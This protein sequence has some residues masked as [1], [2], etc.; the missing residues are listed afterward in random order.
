MPFVNPLRVALGEVTTGYTGT[1]TVTVGATPA[2]YT[3]KAAESP[4]SVM[5]LTL[6]ECIRV[7]GA[8]W[9]VFVDSSDKINFV[10]SG[11]VFSLTA[12]GT[13]EARL[14]LTGA[15][16]A[17]AG[18]TFPNVYSDSLVPDRGAHLD[19]AEFMLDGGVSMSDGSGARAPQFG[20]PTR[21]LFIHDDAADQMAHQALLDAGGTW[22]LLI[23]R[24][25]AGPSFSRFRVLRTSR[26]PMAGVW[27]EWTLSAEVRGVRR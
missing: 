12:T 6:A 25:G 24:P 21:T 10:Y 2:V 13:T 16:S 14:G 4:L 22:D 11:G 3:A 9:S 17:A 7:H 15:L 27:S 20:S 5:Y 18:Y 1:V 26:Q 8:G 19:G 23:T